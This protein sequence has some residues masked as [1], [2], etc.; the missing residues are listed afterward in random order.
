MRVQPLKRRAPRRGDIIEI[1]FSPSAGREMREPHPA[2]V[3]SRSEYNARFRFVTVLEITTVGRVARANGF[4]VNLMN[5]PT[6]TKGVVVCDK[7][8]SLDL[9]ARPWRVIEPCPADVLDE[10]VAIACQVMGVEI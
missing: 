5:C 9:D 8:R 10:A 4:A 7:P 1:D 6:R 2:L 3:V